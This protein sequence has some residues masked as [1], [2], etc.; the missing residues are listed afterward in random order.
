MVKKEEG[1]SEKEVG[2]NE[3]EVADFL[4]SKVGVRITGTSKAI[5]FPLQL[6][7]HKHLT[8]GVEFIDAIPKSTSGK[9]LCCL[10]I[11]RDQNK[12]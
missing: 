3:K 1:L 10:L 6:S 4:A 8:G 11:I 12:E 9:I 2:L 5:M 7:S